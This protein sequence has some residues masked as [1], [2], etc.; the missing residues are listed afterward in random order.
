[1]LKNY[2]DLNKRGW[3]EREE[4]FFETESENEKKKKK[5][6]TFLILKKI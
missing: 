6:K 3:K 5:I 2:F 4:K 1:M